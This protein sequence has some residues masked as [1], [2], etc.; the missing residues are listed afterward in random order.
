MSHS[1]SIDRIDR[2]EVRLVGVSLV[3]AIPGFDLPCVHTA[4]TLPAFAALGDADEVGRHY[5]RLY[6]AYRAAHAA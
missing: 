3:G 5:A 1:A 4:S 2:H 6:G